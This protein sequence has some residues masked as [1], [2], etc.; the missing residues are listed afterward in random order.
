MTEYKV[1]C[2]LTLLL[3][4][5][6]SAPLRVKALNSISGR[7]QFSGQSRNVM[8][9][10]NRIA[11]TGRGVAT[12]LAA[13][14][15]AQVELQKEIMIYNTMKRS[16]EP[17]RPMSAPLVRFYS[18]GPTV[19][20]FAHIGNFRAFLT[21][22]VLKRWLEY[23]GYT[24]EHVCNLT[25]IDDKIIAKMK[26]ENLTMKELTDKYTAAFFEDLDVNPLIAFISLSKMI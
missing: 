7:S 24:V 10:G 1:I 12:R 13:S 25:D 21:Y 8:L 15:S 3:S 2:I 5:A 9:W 16:K 22:D 20:D 26:V 19:Y 6:I 14:I 23:C 18:C 4:L 11:I 17:F